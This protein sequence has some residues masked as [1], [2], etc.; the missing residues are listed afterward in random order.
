VT[1]TKYLTPIKEGI[2][3][4]D[5]EFSAELM[6]YFTELHGK[7]EDARSGL[8]CALTQLEQDHPARE[9][10]ERVHTVMAEAGHYASIM[11]A[12]RGVVDADKSFMN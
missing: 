9:T 5:P 2:K 3:D 12:V 6:A 11:M 1:I 10:V 7:I 8:A 4:C